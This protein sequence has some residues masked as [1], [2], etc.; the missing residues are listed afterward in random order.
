LSFG[1]ALL[2]GYG[3]AL[4]AGIVLMAL[5]SA[6]RSHKRAAVVG[7]LAAFVVLLLP[8]VRYLPDAAAALSIRTAMFWQGWV[9]QSL[10]SLWYFVLPSAAGVG[11][12]LVVLWSGLVAGFAFWRWRSVWRPLS[13]QAAGQRSPELQSKS[14]LHA[15][16][17]A[18]AALTLILS[19]SSNSI[20]YD[21]VIVL[22]GALI[23]ACA[24]GSLSSPRTAREH[25]IGAWL[26]LTMFWL[27]AF[28]VH[29][30]IGRA[31]APQRELPTHALGL[32]SLSLL[33]LTQV[34]SRVQPR[35]FASSGRLP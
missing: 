16:A 14:A 25:V 5:L 31:V 34:T 21:G 22:P 29:R 24:Q 3:L 35:A 13:A 7:S 28:S 1:G 4:A 23:I 2:K 15:S 33:L 19:S 27:C 12:V 32:F 17:F 6:S 11:R 26:A 18:T 10:F 9:N 30:L 20:A 8:V